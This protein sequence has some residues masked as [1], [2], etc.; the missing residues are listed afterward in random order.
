MLDHAA[1][2][3]FAEPDEYGLVADRLDIAA[4]HRGRSE[5]IETQPVVAPF[6]PPR[7]PF[8]PPPMLEHRVVA[9]NREQ[10]ESLAAT[11]GPNIGLTVTPSNIQAEESRVNNA[12]GRGGSTKRSGSSLA[13]AS[14]E[15][16]FSRSQSGSSSLMV[17]P[18]MRWS[19]SRGAGSFS[20]IPRISS[21]IDHPTVDSLATASMTWTRALSLAASASPSNS[22]T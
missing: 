2:G 14:N 8:L 20:S 22:W 17:R 12:F 7:V 5:Q 13:A 1:S 15:T 6:C 21:T 9:V 16:R 4:L 19:A 10:V 18:P 11:S 3:P